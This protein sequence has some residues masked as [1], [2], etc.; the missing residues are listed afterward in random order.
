MADHATTAF[1]TRAGRN[2]DGDRLH[3][4]SAAARAN[5]S[6]AV[7]RQLIDAGKLATETEGRIVYVSLTALRQALAAERGERVGESRRDAKAGVKLLE[8]QSEYSRLLADRGKGANRSPSTPLPHGFAPLEQAI[9]LT[10]K[11]Y[12][13]KPLKVLPVAK[14]LIEQRRL[15]YRGK[16][17]HV[18][19]LIKAV[20]EHLAATPP[21]PIPKADATDYERLREQVRPSARKAQPTGEYERLLEQRRPRPSRRSPRAA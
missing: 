3:I 16:L 17:V 8:D 20:E 13:I 6:P 21:P 7:V 1:R 19:Q 4:Q 10:A 15:T 14:R 12:G 2:D 5:V 11:H 9:E 18:K